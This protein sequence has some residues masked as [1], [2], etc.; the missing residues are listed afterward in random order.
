MALSKSI[1]LNMSGLAMTYWRIIELA[2]DFAANNTRVIL[3]GYADSSA[4]TGGKQPAHTV[5]VKLPEIAE[6]RADAY[7]RLKSP[8]TVAETDGVTDI[9]LF[10]GSADA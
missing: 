7:T 6:T 9:N 8:I 3:A 2:H 1:E 4:R 5:T 10:T